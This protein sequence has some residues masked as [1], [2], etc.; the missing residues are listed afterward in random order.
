MC[1]FLPQGH[2]GGVA[3]VTYLFIHLGV[4]FWWVFWGGVGGKPLVNTS[5]PLK[6]N[7]KQYQINYIFA[8]P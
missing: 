3:P 2:F 5:F 6:K 8:T 1:G 7:K 4:C